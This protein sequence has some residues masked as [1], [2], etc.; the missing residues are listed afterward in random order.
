MPPEGWADLRIPFPRL[1]SKDFV[2]I[3]AT[4]VDS[5]G[6]FSRKNDMMRRDNHNYPD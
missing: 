1:P 6:W 2:S 4:I 3:F 5:S